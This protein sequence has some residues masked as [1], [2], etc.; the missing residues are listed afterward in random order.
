MARGD[1]LVDLVLIVGAI[2]GEGSE[3]ITDL[4]ERHRQLGTD[5]LTESA[6]G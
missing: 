5:R 4:V 6:M 3:R 2:A 1:R